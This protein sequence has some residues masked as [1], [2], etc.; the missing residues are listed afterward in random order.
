[1]GQPLN[2]RVADPSRFSRVGG[3]GFFSP[4]LYSADG[5]D[6]DQSVLVRVERKAAPG[7]VLGMIDQFSLQ[8]VHVHVVQLLDSLFQTPHVEVVELTLPEAR[9]R[10]VAA[11]EGQTQLRGGRSLFV[12]QA[13]RDALLQNLNHGGRR[14]LGW[15]ADQQVNVFRHDHITDERKTVALADLVQDLD[16]SIFGANRTQ[17]RHASITA[18]RDEMKMPAPVD[19]N[20]FVGHGIEGH[21]NPDPSKLAK[22]LPPGK[23]ETSH[24]ALTY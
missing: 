13:A 21:Q 10:I 16:K 2:F 17:E 15:F 19:P 9:Q 14:P 8:R 7:P 5:V 4:R 11:G 23:S 3:F 20:E 6:A 12:A 22:G 18:E 24:S 1:V